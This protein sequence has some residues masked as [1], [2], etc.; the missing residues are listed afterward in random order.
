MSRQ[1]QAKR[2]KQ[3]GVILWSAQAEIAGKFIEAAKIYADHPA[4]CNRVP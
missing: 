4:A 2:E 3:A 1:A